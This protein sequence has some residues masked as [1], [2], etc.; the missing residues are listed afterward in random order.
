LTKIASNFPTTCPFIIKKNKKLHCGIKNYQK[1]QK[2][3]II[4]F[5][6]IIVFGGW[7][8]SPIFFRAD[9][10]Y[11]LSQFFVV[12]HWIDNVINLYEFFG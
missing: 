11:P 5:L 10:G 12:G 6:K 8:Q 3:K 7:L 4:S 2:I 9:F 1:L